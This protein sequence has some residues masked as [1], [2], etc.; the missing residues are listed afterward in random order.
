MELWDLYDE[1]RQPLHRTHVR[2]D[3]FG[4]GEHHLVSDIWT[5]DSLGRLL[6]TQRHPSKPHGLLWECT[7]GSVL[8][9][10]DSVAGALRELSEE[11]GVTARPEELTLL[12]TVRLQDR[13]VDTYLL[14]RDLDPDKL[15]L[16]PTE[17]VGARLVSFPELE[18]LWE[19]GLVVP[20][21]RF[22]LYHTALEAQARCA[23][24]LHPV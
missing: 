10:E 3:P 23:A 17:V 21:E 20:R 15:T 2:G 14:R 1:H 6:L 9:G 5:I 8:A 18:V 13:F 22:I 16:Q 24:A 7:G 11:I 19:A 12:H 4:P